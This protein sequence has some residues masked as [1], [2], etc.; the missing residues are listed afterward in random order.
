MHGD[1]IVAPINATEQR[2]KNVGLG[3]ANSKKPDKKMGGK[4]KDQ[5]RQS[6]MD[7]FNKLF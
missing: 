2:N 3:H 7:R 1:G 5:V 6:A 4:Y